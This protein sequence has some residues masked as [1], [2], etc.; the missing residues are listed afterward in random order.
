MPVYEPE[1]HQTEFGKVVEGLIRS[2]P[3]AQYILPDPYD[4]SSY[5]NPVAGL[6]SKPLKSGVK[7]GKNFAADLF[8]KE[9]RMYR[10]ARTGVFNSAR[11][12][13][14]LEKWLSRVPDSPEKGKA[15]KYLDEFYSGQEYPD[16]AL[17]VA[18]E[19]LHEAL[20]KL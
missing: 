17:E 10:D 8:T 7:A 9:T 11:L 5:I 4:P 18:A 1:K 13:K 14:V 6:A 16:V 12:Q 19:W 2:I 20:R 3:G 15:I